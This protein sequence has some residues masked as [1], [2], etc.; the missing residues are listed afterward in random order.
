M[1]TMELVDGRC[2]DTLQREFPRIR[3]VAADHLLEL[4]G[5]DTGLELHAPLRTAPLPWPTRG[6]RPR[7]LG[8]CHELQRHGFGADI[9]AFNILSGKRMTAGRRR[10]PGAWEPH[11]VRFWSDF[12][13]LL[14]RLGKAGRCRQPLSAARGYL[15]TVPGS[16]STH[17]GLCQARRYR[18]RDIHF[19]CDAYRD[20]GLLPMMGG[21]SIGLVIHERPIHSR[22][23][24]GEGGDVHRD[25]KLRI[26][27]SLGRHDCR[28]QQRR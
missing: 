11:A 25:R 17:L 24:L 23:H 9:V 2:Y 16:P 7:I 12:P 14:Q 8:G 19:A 27:L 6:Q 28:N 3:W 18:G 1:R 20:Q 26:A 15:R 22:R 13:G 21:H 5:E 10:A 4:R